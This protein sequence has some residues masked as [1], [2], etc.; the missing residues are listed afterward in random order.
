MTLFMEKQALK[1]VVLV[2]APNLAQKVPTLS[3]G[4][5]RLMSGYF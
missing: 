4:D 5:V 2:T 1:V 3:Q